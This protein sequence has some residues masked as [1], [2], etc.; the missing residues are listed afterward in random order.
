MIDPVPDERERLEAVQTAVRKEDDFQDGRK[1]K[2]TDFSGSASSGKRKRNEPMAATAKKPKYTTKEKRVY[3][4]KKKEERAAK[5]PVAPRQEIMHRVWADVHTGIDQKEIDEWKARKQCTRCTLTNH[6]WKYC[7][8]EIRISSIQRRPF[9]L[10]V[11]HTQNP[12]D[13]ENRG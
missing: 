3:Q 2:N 13:L 10:P 6:G 12:P 7:K 5:K 8:K 1:L 4:A 9:K 11:G